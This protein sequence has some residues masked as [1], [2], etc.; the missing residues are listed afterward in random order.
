M[1]KTGRVQESHS[2]TTYVAHPADLKAFESQAPKRSA[3]VEFDIDPQLLKQTKEGWAAVIGPNSVFGRL[4]ARKGTPVTQMPEAL[5]IEHNASK[6]G[7]Y[8]E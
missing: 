1:R 2:G 5:N 4:L 8:T 6:L 7:N 3:Y